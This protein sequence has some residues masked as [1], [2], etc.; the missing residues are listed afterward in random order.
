M[1]ILIIAYVL[2]EPK[3]TGSGAR[4]MELIHLFLAQ[5]WSVHMA[6][7]AQATDYSEDL[8]ALGIKTS[9]ITV[10][11][12]GFDDFIAKMNPNIVLF[13]R[14]VM[15]EQFGWRVAKQ[16]PDAMRMLETIDLHCLR[17]ARHK[18]AK[19]N[20][21][22]AL[23]PNQADLY[24]AIALREIASIYRSDISL[25]IS[26]YEIEV[27][28]KYF[29][30]PKSI[31]HLCPFMLDASDT[32][33]LPAFEQRQHFISIGNFRHA[34]NWDAVLWLK[35]DIWPLLRKQLPQAE[36]HIYG[37]YTP[38]KATALHNAKEGFLIKDRADSVQDVMQQARINFAPL[39]FG[40][41]LKTKLA[42]AMM[43]GTPSVSTSIGEEG[44]TGGLPWSGCVEDYA[45]G[46]ADAAV[47]LY[48]DKEAWDKAQSNGF[49]IVNTLFHKEKNQQ[50][51]LQRILDVRDNLETYRQQNFTGQMLNHH[52]HR[53]TE[54]MSRWI[55][56]KNKPSD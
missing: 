34:P 35:Q 53:S 16:C 36:L 39:R 1:K 54:F 37:A 48:Q 27:L 38:P 46:F 20:Q 3:S 14:F 8:A 7:P 2:P 21:A 12:G 42:D 33:N 26:D 4:M 5:D 49:K 43:F 17:E 31:L 25:L 56:A 47:R 15:E 41:G 11:E 6:S 23:E 9:E 50:T 45:Q 19:R 29:N 22:V 13:D 44:M 10:N 55:E 52:H 28:K 40:A 51:L 24:S 18:Q 32:E 30:V